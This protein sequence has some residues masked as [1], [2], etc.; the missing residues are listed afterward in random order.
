MIPTYADAVTSLAPKAGFAFRDGVIEKWD[1]NDTKIPQPTEDEINAK[2]TELIAAY[3]LQEL[4]EKRNAL[5]ASSDWRDLP[6]YAG[7]KQAEWRVY[8]QALRDLPS[9]AK[10]KLDKSARLTGFTWP[11]K[12]G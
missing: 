12:P 9:T 10:P 3:P 4:R 11:E 8:R 7:T 1:I 2:L 5:L 6:S